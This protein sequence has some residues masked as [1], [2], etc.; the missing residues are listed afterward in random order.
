MTERASP[1][2]RPAAIADMKAVRDIYAHHVTTGTSTFEVE[3]PDLQEMKRRL[4]EIEGRGFPFLVAEADGRVGGYAYANLYRTREA[5][6][7][8]VEDSVYIDQGMRGQGLGKA[9]LTAL[10]K[11]SEKAGMRQMVAVIGGSDN[12]ASIRLHESLGFNRVGLLPA[13]GFKLGRWCDSVL[14]QRSL[15]HGAA[16]MPK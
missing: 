13:V 8:T 4:A 16:T 1:I 12:E 15:G 7:F 10:I 11:A 2:V 3:A 6:R 9:L 14:M 5:Y